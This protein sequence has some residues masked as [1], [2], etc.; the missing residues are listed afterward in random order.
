MEEMNTGPAIEVITLSKRY[1][2]PLPLG[3]WRGGT[4]RFGRDA[5]T[6]VSFE[7]ATGEVVALIG[8]E[9][10]PACSC[11]PQEGPEWRSSTWSWIGPARGR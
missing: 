4:A 1:P 6:S 3:G 9:F 8:F 10:F 11:P 5:L 2:A 7:V